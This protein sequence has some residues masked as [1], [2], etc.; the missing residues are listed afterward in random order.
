M[1]EKDELLFSTKY[2]YIPSFHSYYWKTSLGLF[3]DINFLIHIDRYKTKRLNIG[4]DSKNN[5]TPFKFNPKC[6]KNL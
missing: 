1:E 2:G 4:T 5:F 3:D 6:H